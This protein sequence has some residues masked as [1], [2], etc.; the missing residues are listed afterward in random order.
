MWWCIDVIAALYSCIMLHCFFALWCVF[1]TVMCCCCCSCGCA[2]NMGIVIRSR[3]LL[4][5][6][7]CRKIGGWRKKGG[8]THF[9]GDL[10]LCPKVS[11][12]TPKKMCEKWWNVWIMTRKYDLQK[13]G[14]MCEKRTWAERQQHP[15]GKK[16]FPNYCF[17][18]KNSR[19]QFLANCRNFCSN[20]RIAWDRGIFLV[21]IRSNFF[22]KSYV[23][24][25]VVS[26]FIIANDY[27]SLRIVMSVLQT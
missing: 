26:I 4:V 21:D 8:P 11:T 7:S 6:G 24:W 2:Y 23:C 1:G 5:I 14:E 25:F 17:L 9:N 10:L 16:F 15:L 13:M 27:N 20:V 12:N 3:C 19:L 18:S 22:R